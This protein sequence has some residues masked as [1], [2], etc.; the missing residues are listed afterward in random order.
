MGQWTLPEKKCTGTAPITCRSLC[1]GF[2]VPFAIKKSPT[3]QLP[4]LLS[5]F[6]KRSTNTWLHSVFTRVPMRDTCVIT[7]HRRVRGMMVAQKIQSFPLKSVLPLIISA[8][9]QPTD[10]M[11]TGINE[12]EKKKTS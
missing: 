10:Q 8:M 12:R 7:A 3:S 4:L 1:T 9:M 11:S 2:T 6:L 5:A